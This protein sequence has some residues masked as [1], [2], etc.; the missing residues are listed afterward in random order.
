MPRHANYTGY[1]Q[2]SWLFILH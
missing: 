2:L 1:E